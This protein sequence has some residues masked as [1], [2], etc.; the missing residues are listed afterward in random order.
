ATIDF[1]AGTVKRAPVWM[2]RVGMEW[3]YRLAQEPRRLFKRYFKDL[4]VFGWKILGQLWQL[5]LRQNGS[6]NHGGPRTVSPPQRWIEPVLSENLNVRYNFPLSP[7]ER[8]GVRGKDAPAE[9]S[10][11]NFQTE[12]TH[13][14]IRIPA[15]LDLATVCDEAPR[16]EPAFNGTQHCLLDMSQ[17]QFID[18]TGVGLL[19]RLQKKIRADGRQL[20]LLAPTAMVTRALELMRLEKFF[21]TASDLPSAQALIAARMR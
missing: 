19:I 12:T 4:W 21:D 20:V 9:L 6:A 2:Q 18:S 10:I 14:L 5:Q 3:I 16:L 8:A 11:S 7:G 15:R 1:L 13:Q 17:V